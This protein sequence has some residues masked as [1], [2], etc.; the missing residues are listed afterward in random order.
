MVTTDNREWCSAYLGSDRPYQ[1]GV[2]EAD[3]RLVESF[4]YHDGRGR[5][6]RFSD[7][8]GHCLVWF[9]KRKRDIQ[10]GQTF[11]VSFVI[12]SHREFNGVLENIAKEF[13]ILAEGSEREG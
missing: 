9:T 11:R 4:S 3:V 12:K 6:F 5:C 13:R 7:L 1:D 10:I 8:E 2:R